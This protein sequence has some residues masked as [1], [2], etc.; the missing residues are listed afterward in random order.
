MLRFGQGIM[1]EHQGREIRLLDRQVYWNHQAVY[2]DC[3]YADGYSR[4]EDRFVEAVLRDLFQGVEGAVLDVG[5]GTGL[6]LE[7]L[8]AHLLY[9]GL[10]IAENMLALARAKYNG[11]A[12]FVHHDAEQRLPFAGGAFDGLLA[13][14]TTFSYFMRP[15]RAAAEFA[16]VLRPGSPIVVMALGRRALWRHGVQTA[17]AIYRTRN[18]PDRRHGV[19]ARFYT[20]RELARVFRPEF[21]S[22][23]VQALSLFGGWAEDARLWPLDRLLCRLRP[24]L[25]HSLV[26]K[27]RKY[28]A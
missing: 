11:R 19:P 27:G 15:D 9:T 8:P 2:Y 17:A 1:R 22:V 25:A 26:L 18:S 10:D 28:H 20:S 16:R 3:L 5:C 23:Q 6:G 7:L 4:R 24:D 14:H 21:E 13:L 12:T